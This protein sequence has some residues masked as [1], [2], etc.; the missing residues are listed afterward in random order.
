ME[1]EL[2]KYCRNIFSIGRYL[3]NQI[4]SKMVDIQLMDFV[5]RI[6]FPTDS[7]AEI[8]INALAH[9]KLNHTYTGPI[10]AEIVWLDRSIQEIEQPPFVEENYTGFGYVAYS[11]NDQYQIAD[12]LM[13]GMSVVFDKKNNFGILITNT[14]ENISIYVKGA[15]FINLIQ[16]ISRKYGWFM[17]H[18]ASIGLDGKGVLLVGNSG[19]GK[20]TTALSTLLSDHM[21]YLCD[22]RCMVRLNPF[23]QALA[24]YNSVKINK[25]VMERLPFLKNKI[26]DT[27][28]LG[29]KGKGL[30]F[31]YPDLES[32]MAVSL[33]IKSILIP[34]I[35][36]GEIPQLI[37][38]NSAEAFRVMAPSSFLQLPGSEPLDLK[39]MSNLLSSLPCYYLNLTPNLQSN[40]AVI[41]EHLLT[42]NVE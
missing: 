27:D 34:R 38:T 6:Y 42:H 3:A 18:A 4:H 20:S 12:F 29:K 17:A 36:G 24:I 35:S 30:A 8:M 22:D 41:Y 19:A 10:A 11:S 31:L 39:I 23:P 40:I 37:P 16:W 7:R 21:E 26:V 2:T 14:L 28:T 33:Q 25:D 15:P 13:K 1:K 32:R 5:I 9:L